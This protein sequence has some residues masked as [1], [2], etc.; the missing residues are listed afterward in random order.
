[1]EHRALKFTRFLG[2]KTFLITALC[3]MVSAVQSQTISPFITTWQTDAS[4]NII[5]PLTGAGYDFSINWGDGAVEIKTGTP[6]NISHNYATA[7]VYTVT[8]TPNTLTGF[9]RI[10]INNFGNR[11]LLRT[12]AQ[13]GG[14]RWSNMNRSFYGANAM[15]IT[16]TDTP[17]FSAVTSFDGTFLECTA[18]TGNP[19][20]A[21]W[22]FS[23]DPG[24]NIDMSAMFQSA[25]NFNQD[26]SSWNMERVTNMRQIFNGATVF[27]Q[28]LNSWDVSNA[29]NM[30]YLFANTNSFNNLGNALV[31]GN[32]VSKVT[33][34]NNM[35]LN[36]RAFNQDISG[37]DVSNVIDMSSMFSNAQAFNSPL[38]TWN[39]GKVTNMGSMFYD[40]RVF[41]QNISAWDVSKV[42]NMNSMLRQMPLFNQPL[43]GWGAKTGN[44]T[45]MQ[46]MFR[47]SPLFNQSLNSWDVSKV[48]TTSLMFY[49]ANSFNQ[50]L[51]SWNFASLVNATSMFQENSAFN[52]N[53]TTWQFS[54]DPTRSIN[55]SNMF[56]NAAKFNQD[57]SAWNVSRVISM[58]GMFT[59]T[60][61]FNQDISAWD[62]SNVTDMANMFNNAQAFNS[63]LNWA[64]KTAKVTNMGSMF[65]STRLFNQDISGWNVS[66]VTNM[67]SMFFDARVFN[68]NISAWDVTKVTNMA[69]MFRQMPLFNQP[70][71]GWGTKTGRVTNMQE[72]FR[73]SPIFNQPLNSWD[74][75]KVTN[76]IYMFYRTNSFNQ[77]LNSWDLS[78]LTNGTGMFQENTAFN[79]NISNWKFSTGTPATVNLTSMFQS[80]TSFDKNLGAWNISFVNSLTN[81]LNGSKI[82]RQNYDATLKGWSTLDAGETR[83]PTGLNVHFGTS[84]YSNDATVI[85]AR[86]ALTSGRTWA[87]TDGGV[88]TDYTNPTINGNVLAANNNTI[89]I[90][91]SDRAFNS[92]KATSNLK[93]T[94]F[95][96]S[97]AGGV[98]ALSSVN[99]TSITTSDNITFVLGLGF[100]VPANGAEILTV[101]PTASSIFDAA[102]NE[103]GVPQSNN[104]A[105]LNDLTPPVISGPAAATGA[106]SSI[107]VEENQTAVF[108]FT[109]NEA[110]TWS[111][112]TSD[113]K[114]LF[115]ITSSG[116]VTF[117]ESP[118]FEIPSDANTDNNYLIEVVATDAKGNISKQIVTITV[119]DVFD[120]PA[121]LSNFN[122]Q[123]KMYFDGS[124]TIS[125]PTSNN[126]TG[127]FTY[128]SSNTAVATIS[129]STV[130]LKGIGVSTIK[131]TQAG[132]GYYTESSISATLT[133]TSVDVLTNHGELSNT[134]TN[135]VNANGAIGSNIGVDSNGKLKTTKSLNIA[136][137]VM[138]LD[139]DNTSSYSGTG[140]T[141]FDL[142]GNNNHISWSAPAPQ[143]TTD[144]GIKVIKTTDATGVLRAMVSTNYNNLPTGNEPYTAISF[145]KPNSTDAAKMILSLGPANNLCGGTQIHP[146]GIGT[147]GKYAGGSCGGLGTWQDNTGVTPSTSSYVCVAT[148]YGSSTEKVY[149]NGNL[150][151]TAT[152]TTNIPV[153]AAN[154]VSIGWVRD[155]GA[156]YTMDANIGIILFY[157]RELSASEITQIYNTYRLRFGL[158]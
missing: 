78:S 77:D 142:S 98:A 144:N 149:V 96:F 145:F 93:I 118:D 22:R 59:S 116:V 124:F 88:E 89:T 34:M 65:Q 97:I 108:S 4:R 70:L 49:R 153:S 148:T 41:N 99:P 90:T 121:T 154:K 84:K 7:G 157:N 47:D 48:T 100:S 150:D 46:E 27:N 110:V 29:T 119:T 109:A 130:T 15:Q 39:V 32:K 69:N 79:G 67:G 18:L 42:T 105:H 115:A 14:G 85:A 137:L 35:F 158:N 140:N 54:T 28:D 123:N 94:D 136:G 44:V 57:I 138:H 53:I 37:W 50:D 143:F 52:G 60:T 95:T 83:I 38:N 17:D 23:T 8:I 86:T 127:A 103:L 111:L 21:N 55:L 61:F 31:W 56:N 2:V 106:S 9:P 129:G 156:N 139:A 26:I 134:K 76:T 122:A 63:P 128:T 62:V 151:R 3:L 125:P 133:V 66:S 117:N 152:M 104:T 107:S 11:A 146:I 91:L 141:W 58:N 30:N 43:D 82:C 155:D 147:S 51:P 20:M 13:W 68:Q 114:V 36:A 10:L 113:D 131:A 112:G 19:S 75:S 87:V 132:D 102:G 73:D 16:A 6:N 12:I 120:L 74:V 135:Y 80:A 40:A 25:S 101:N 24:F 71:D 72:M 33:S 92:C 64:A 1:M 126:S 45:N 5:I 81:F